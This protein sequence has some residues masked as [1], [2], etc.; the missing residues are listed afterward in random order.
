MHNAKSS[1]VSS[2]QDELQNFQAA[3]GAIALLANQ[4]NF[5][6]LQ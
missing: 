4:N 2:L 1:K 3:G 6:F 5:Y